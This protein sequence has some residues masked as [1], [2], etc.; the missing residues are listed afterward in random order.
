M[1]PKTQESTLD[2]NPLL[3]LISSGGIYALENI[4]SF[5]SSEY[6]SNWEN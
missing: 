1:T 5:F 4:S 6:S 3:L 2:V